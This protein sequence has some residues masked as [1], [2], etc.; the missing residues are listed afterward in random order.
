M[1]SSK[2]SRRNSPPPKGL[3]PEG[4]KLWQALVREYGIDD[5][6]GLS[7]L[8]Q[9]CEAHDRCQAAKREL[10][11]EGVTIVDRWKQKRIHPACAVERDARAQYLAALKALNLDLEPLR[12]GPGRPG[13]GY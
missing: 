1:K 13:G 9:A 4:R 3:S 5:P 10:D 12:D 2:S 11:A 6:A 8:R 7:I